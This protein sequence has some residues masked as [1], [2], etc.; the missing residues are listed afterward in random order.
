MYSGSVVLISLSQS[1][2]NPRDF[3][4]RL[5]LSRFCSVVTR[6]CWPVLMAYCSA[7]SPNASH[8]M[9]CRTL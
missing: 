2:P 5:K 8:P 9:G 7:G 6:G 3:S 1:Y 4:W